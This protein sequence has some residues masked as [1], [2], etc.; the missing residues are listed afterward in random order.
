MYVL[1]PSVTVVEP[2]VAESFFPVTVTG[3]GWYQ[4]SGVKVT[5]DLSS[6]PSAVPALSIVTGTLTVA[7]GALSSLRLKVSVVPDSR[8]VREVLSTMM[9]LIFPSTVTLSI[10]R[11]SAIGSE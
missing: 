5:D 8:V 4:S 10:G 7:V 6:V 9:A 1:V 2:D 3:C 11:W